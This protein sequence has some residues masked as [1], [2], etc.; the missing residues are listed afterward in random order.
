MSSKLSWVWMTDLFDLF[1]QQVKYHFCHAI[2]CT[3]VAGLLCQNLSWK[4]SFISWQHLRTVWLA[5]NFS[6]CSQIR[7]AS[8]LSL[9]SLNLSYFRLIAQPVLSYSAWDYCQT[10]CLSGFSFSKPQA[11]VFI[12]LLYIVEVLTFFSVYQVLLT[13]KDLLLVLYKLL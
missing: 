1:V 12:V 8:M 3:K 4:P 2:N 9:L 7:Y 10:L 13:F 11:H 5:A 6:N